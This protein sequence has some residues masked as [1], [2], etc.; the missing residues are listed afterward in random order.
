MARKTDL[1][2]VVG[3]SLNK[4][5]VCTRSPE[6]NGFDMYIVWLDRNKEFESGKEFDLQDIE[7]I[8]AVIHFCDIESVEIMINA[9]QEVLEMWKKV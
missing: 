3:K 2:I 6:L 4:G 9:L 1:P 5:I 7:A 8:N